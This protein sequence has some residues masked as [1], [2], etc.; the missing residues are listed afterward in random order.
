LQEVLGDV[1]HQPWGGLGDD[2]PVEAEGLL[3]WFEQ[4]MPVNTM[5]VGVLPPAFPRTAGQ[6]VWEG[7][8]KTLEEYMA[9]GLPGEAVE[10][11]ELFDFLGARSIGSS[12][13][14]DIPQR[15]Q[16]LGF[17]SMTH[18][19]GIRTGHPSHR[20]FVALD[21]SQVKRPWVAAPHQPYNTKLPLAAL[22]GGAG[23]NALARG[24]S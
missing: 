10:G 21:P 20:V 4:G 22:L 14:R 11:K 23:Y 6:K 3:K 2:F 7:V 9:K 1:S 8:P 13:G 24:G 17:D 12:S 5:D 16:D 18:E 15:L 19:G